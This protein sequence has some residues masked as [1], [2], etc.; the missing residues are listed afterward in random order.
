VEKRYLS[1]NS[2]NIEAFGWHR[3]NILTLI[4]SML[5][6]QYPAINGA[7]IKTDIFPTALDLLFKFEHNSFCHSLV[8]KICMSMLGQADTDLV[9]SFIKKTNLHIRI[10]DAEK[11]F[12]TEGHGKITARKE[13]MPVLYHLADKINLIFGETNSRM[14]NYIKG[15]EQEWDNLISELQEKRQKLKDT[16]IIADRTAPRGKVIVEDEEGFKQSAKDAKDTKDTPT[17]TKPSKTKSIADIT[18]EDLLDDK[19]FAGYGDL[20]D[21]VGL[22]DTKQTATN[23]T[24]DIDEEGKNVMSAIDA[25]LDGNYDSIVMDKSKLQGLTLDDI[26]G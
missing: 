1:Q 8:E 7:L 25:I 5:T 19:M 21:L 11:K 17:T 20:D 22:E 24:A 15:R 18:D 2:Q 10:L 6:L 26:L 13:Y 3:F 9:E 23:T 16:D 14:R 12:K 4:N